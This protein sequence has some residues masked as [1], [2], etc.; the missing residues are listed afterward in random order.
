MTPKVRIISLIS[1]SPL[2]TLHKRIFIPPLNVCAPGWH[3]TRGERG[4]R[5]HMRIW[6]HRMCHLWEFWHIRDISQLG[7]FSSPGRARNDSLQ[8]KQSPMWGLRCSDEANV[9]KYLFCI[10]K[11]NMETSRYII[12]KSRQCTVVKFWGSRGHLTF[13]MIYHL[14]CLLQS[15]Y[16]L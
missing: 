13:L 11:T 3:T 7:L 4:A 14:I 15:I 5:T 6:D 10:A 12:I 2:P 9:G 8:T 1:N 16:W